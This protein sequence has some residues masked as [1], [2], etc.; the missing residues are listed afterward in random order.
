MKYSHTALKELNARYG[1]I[2]RKCFLMNIAFCVSLT[3]TSVLALDTE[4]TVTPEQATS[5]AGFSGKN[6]A[7]GNSNQNLTYAYIKG[8]TASTLENAK[9]ENNTTDSGGSFAV[10]GSITAR[11][12][13]NV[14][15]GAEFNSNEAYFDGGAIANYGTLN[16]LNGAVF[17]NNKAQAHISDDEKPIGGG[18]LA[19]GSLSTTKIIKGTFDSNV[20]E[21]DG[22]AVA[23]RHTKDGSQMEAEFNISQSTFTSNEALLNG[24]AVY[25]TFYKTASIE[26]SQFLGNKA[27]LNGGAIYNAEGGSI[28]SN[29]GSIILSNNTYKDN[30]ATSNGGAV[31][32]AGTTTITDSEFS[33]NTAQNYGGAVITRCVTD[34]CTAKTTISNSTFKNNTASIGGAVF[35]WTNSET[36][37]SGSTFDSNTADF[38]GA[39]YT[40]TSMKNLTI[41]DSK[42]L[43]NTALGVGAVGIFKKASLTN[44]TFD[45]N[46]ST[47]ETGSGGGAVFLGALSQT[48]IDGGTFTNNTSASVGGAIAVRSTDEG[49]NSAAKLDIENSTFINN[50]AKTQGGAVFS[51][52]YNS[53]K[54]V[55]SVY[56]A[57]SEFTGNSA[58]E[59]G[60]V[61]N[62]G[63]PDVGG[64]LA[65]MKLK[66]VT[67]KDNTA[68]SNGGAVYNA[69]DGTVNLVGTNTFSNNTVNGVKN[70]IYNDGT[71]NVAGSL[72]LDGGISGSGNIVFDADSTLTAVLDT[73]KISANSVTTNGADLNLVIGDLI[74]D[75]TYDFIT[76]NT[77]DQAF[78]IQENALYDLSM[79]K[80]HQS[81]IVTKKSTED[82]ASSTGA[83]SNEANVIAGLTSGTS[84]NEAFDSL[85]SQIQ[86]SLQ[87]GDPVKIQSAVKAAAAVAPTTA[88]VTQAITTSTITQVLSAVSSRLSSGIT[89]SGA[90]SGD[91]I[92]DEGAVWV[93]GLF[94]RSRLGGTDGFH[95]YSRGLAFGA[96]SQLSVDT[97][98]GF[99]Y[100]YTNSDLKPDDRKSEVDSHSAIIYGE[101]K[102]E[103]WYVNAMA[104]YTWGRHDDQRYAL[105]TLISAKHDVDSVSLQAMTG[106]DVNLKDT[107]IVTPEIGIR[108][109][110]TN[111]KSYTDNLGNKIESNHSDT[112]TGVAG[113]KTSFDWQI[114]DTTVLKPEAKIAL[115]YDFKRDNAGSVMTL[116]NGSVVSVD[117]DSL[118]RFGTELSLGLTTEIDD[119]I[120]L[121]ISWEGKFRQDYTDNT[122]MINL[123]YHF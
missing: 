60:A 32:N 9:F 101:Y 97:K 105:G 18:A 47:D 92:S 16:I 63:K 78:N 77:V 104:A 20:S 102:P 112:F 10:S 113:L 94:N 19:L 11:G 100:A 3:G 30:T 110:N 35:G 67:F 8:V 98:V 76:A 2:L 71:L 48:T 81:I 44:V 54:S 111:E 1:C 37:I 50:T 56:I 26:N 42:F 53:E 24:G 99:G 66:D 86:T 46:K 38:G 45:G 119:S 39:I 14:T 22:G 117:G 115:T 25:N 91:I 12:T 55:D 121:G 73:T 62:S 57:S 28:D 29:A 43:N 74:T 68:T 122:G 27:T 33:G 116:A 90:S 69:G 36:E 49:N 31:Y 34:G 6:T 83:T 65:S 41:S 51:T 17:S 118:K 95:A 84:G 61:Y 15:K 114:S 87:S 75:K 4:W 106:Y 64:N 5:I 89:P 88:P 103:S 109:I 23:T 120:E 85:A 52:F 82:I 70:D 96:E 80:D 123:K 21:G 13:L 79:T 7:T 40:S 93:K 72:T 59:G 58:A 108:Y 107:I